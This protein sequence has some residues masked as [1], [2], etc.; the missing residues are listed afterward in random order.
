[1]ESRPSRTGEPRSK[2]FWDR[3]V[4]RLPLRVALPVA[5]ALV[6]SAG[7]AVTTLWVGGPSRT[8]ASAPAPTG[9][10][11]IALP[12]AG[13]PPVTTTSPAGTT[14]ST[15]AGTSSK[16]PTTAKPPAG[17]TLPGAVVTMLDDITAVFEQGKTTPQYATVVNDHDGC[18]FKAGWASFCTARGDVFTVVS[19]YTDDVPDNPLRRYLPTLQKLG[20]THSDDTSALGD[21]FVNDWRTAAGDRK[22]DEIQLRVG[23]ELFLTPALAIANQLN[24]RSNLGVEDLFDT[25]LMM[26]SSSSD[27]D[28]LPKLITETVIE[29]SG[30]PVSGISEQA[31]LTSFNQVRIKHL[32]NPCTPGR[33]KVWSAAVD[34]VQALQQLADKNC[35]SLNPPLTIGADFNLTIRTPSD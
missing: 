29:A 23:H 32:R 17:P 31:F 15:K 25:A 6:T 33:Q 20:E 8:T 24:I 4:G 34:R 26:G 35:W 5:L 1:M 22:F 19:Q 7:I 28:G 18:G 21:S 16:P 11:V 9:P 14:T 27:C 2:G 10:S 30:T 13:S 3:E 12:P